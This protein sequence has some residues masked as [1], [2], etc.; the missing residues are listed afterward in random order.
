MRIVELLFGCIF[1]GMGLWGVV[2][3]DI[4]VLG[5]KANAGD[6][7][8]ASFGDHPVIFLLAFGL[9]M[10]CGVALIREGLKGGD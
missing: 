5:G 10:L 9:Y 6:G 7:G 1:T 8:W 3:G 4:Y 2:S